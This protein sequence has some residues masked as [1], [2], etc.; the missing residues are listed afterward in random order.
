MNGKSKLRAFGVALAMV[1]SAAGTGWALQLP[2]TAMVADVGSVDLPAPA[3]TPPPSL[4]PLAGPQ[5]DDG[6]PQLARTHGPGQE[7][8]LEE[9]SAT[10]A[11]SV[12]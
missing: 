8:G 4:S 9:M 2:L 1:A 7:V 12:R 6:A 5:S 10:G 3:N 11:A